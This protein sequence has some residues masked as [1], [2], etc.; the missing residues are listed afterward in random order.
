MV[1][2]FQKLSE[3]EAL[4]EVP[5]EVRILAEVDG[6]IKRVPGSGLGGGK[7]LVIT[8]PDFK[9]AQ[10]MADQN[11]SAAWDEFW[12][13]LDSDEKF[14]GAFSTNIT[15]DEAISA[16]RKGELANVVFYT[17]NFVNNYNIP[18]LLA[19]DIADFSIVY[20]SDCLG[21]FLNNTPTF[22]WT[23]NGFTSELP[24]ENDPIPT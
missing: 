14:L 12:N 9:F 24:F 8:S 7:T 3:V 17:T 18:I 6:D 15:F 11:D 5:E 4:A 13:N 21:L 10:T 16:F 23:S 22:C 1:Y 19:I 2:E 20:P